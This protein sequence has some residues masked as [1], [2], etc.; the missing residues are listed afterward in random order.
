MACSLTKTT[1][2][3]IKQALYWIGQIDFSGNYATGG[4]SLDTAFTD[5]GAFSTKAPFIVWAQD[6]L[7][8]YYF[9]YVRSTN[10]LAIFTTADGAQLAAG[11]YPA[12]LTSGVIEIQAILHKLV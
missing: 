5:A 3:D 12:G 6:P 2:L 4:E 9:E 10:K 1:S 7:G 11:A 8:V